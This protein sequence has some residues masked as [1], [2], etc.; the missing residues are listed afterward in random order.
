MVRFVDVHHLARWVADTG[1]ESIISD[2]VDALEAD[3]RRWPAFDKA[4][5]LASHSGD[6]VI[7][8]MPTSDG[9]TYAFKFVNGHPVNTSRGLQTVT[10]FGVLADVATGYPR[11]L[12]EMTLLTALR[13]AAT[14]VMAARALAPPGAGTMALI[15]TGAQAEFQALAFHR[16]LGIDTIRAWDTDPAA[17]D[18]F[19]TNAAQLGLDVVRAT[20]ADDAI[21]G[22][23]IITTCTADKRNATVLT[24]DMVRRA[25]DGGVHINALGG[26]CP[27]KTELDIELVKRS[28]LFVE[29]AEQSFIEG[30]IQ[31]LPRS[32]PV[33]ELWQVLTGDRPGRTSP[34][35]ITVFDS[36]G[37]AV[38]DFTALSYLDAALDREGGDRY[39]ERIELVAEPAD[40]KN[41]FQ[42]V[43]DEMTVDVAGA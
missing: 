9:G 32:W 17:L 35:E 29:Y 8:L 19:V 1:L 28:S 36:V 12:S 34:D 13:T 26:D 24:D 21:A 18:K 37:F 6:G 14:S 2:L 22:A 27:G 20:G 16:C 41:L 39:F 4:P 3:F 23:H 38:E 5:R 25:T 42:L 15:G 30:E 10:A 31:H 40:P 7:E 33:T 11:L 43:E